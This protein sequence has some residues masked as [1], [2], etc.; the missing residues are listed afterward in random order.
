MACVPQVGIETIQRLVWLEGSAVVGVC[1]QVGIGD[2]VN[3]DEL[4]A[5]ASFPQNYTVL[6]ATNFSTLAG[7]LSDKL[8]MALCS[9]GSCLVT[10]LHSVLMKSFIPIGT[11]SNPKK[12]NA[13]FISSMS[14][15]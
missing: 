5:I 13:L 4:N 11:P 14:Y 1:A 2:Q 8:S 7:Q 9:S 12:K 6:L 15:A 3:L 10:S